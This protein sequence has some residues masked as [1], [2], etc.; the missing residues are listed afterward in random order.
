MSDRVIGKTVGFFAG[1]PP[2]E[3]WFAAAMRERIQDRFR[4]PDGPVTRS[5]D[6]EER[7]I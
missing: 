5:P 2:E 1:K 3:V 7:G 6:L 4:S